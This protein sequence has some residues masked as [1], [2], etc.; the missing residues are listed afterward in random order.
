MNELLLSNIIPE[1][2]LRKV[3]TNVLENVSN[4]IMK[5]AGPYGS[6]TMIIRQKAFAT[7]SKDG[8]KVLDNIKYYGP[9][10][11][12]I[13]DEL[14]QMTSYVVKE[15]GDGT[16]SAIRMSYYIFKELLSKAG[17]SWSE[18]PTHSIIESFKKVTRKISDLIL[19]HGRELTLG[20]IYDICMVSTNGDK[21]ISNSIAMIYQKYGADVNIDIGTSNTA[22]HM[23]KEYDGLILEKGY[24]S[25][26]YINTK[27]GH[28]IINNANIYYFKDP[29]DTPEMVQ[30]FTAI[31]TN[32]IIVPI[33]ERRM[34]PIPTVIMCPHIS[35]DVEVYLDEI[36]T[37][38]Y[39]CKNENTKPPILII[40]GLNRY[41]E[42]LDDICRLCGAKPI[43][44]YIDPKIQEH[45][46]EAGKAPSCENIYQWCGKAKVVDADSTKTKFI[47]PDNMYTYNEDGSRTETEVYSGLVTFLQDQL[48]SAQEN[49]EDISVIRK[50]KKRLMA[51]SANMVQY[52]IGGI[53]T[54][55]VESAKDLTEDAVLNCRAACQNGIGF[56]AN[57]EGLIASY[58]LLN[59]PDDSFTDLD[60][61]MLEVIFSAY[62]EFSIELYA[63]AMKATEAEK[64]VKASIEMG[65]PMNLRTLKYD[66]KVLSSINTDAVIL[67][68][69]SRIII[70]MFTANQGLTGEP[71]EN[72]YAKLKDI[73][74]TDKN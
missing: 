3:Q 41:T 29:I 24:P 72:K 10:E 66:G 19:S 65:M 60:V 28:C 74:M 57:F 55:D 44:K 69:I 52:L 11:N 27:S 4:A 50:L 26:A 58:E 2:N 31:I 17:D 46:I 15:V 67:E 30:F 6:N 22:E 37:M 47:E 25:N 63:T 21:D 33:T 34:E 12:A 35:R 43:M 56:G 40:S 23:Y 9:L 1:E 16:T 14:S 64:E 38:L 53:S 18:Y 59:N 36:E 61:E 54:S 45:D 70:I 62:K 71:L 68:G 5:T 39:G 13:V 20:D 8:K 49:N 73:D 7:Y 51:L 42:E 32:N 48:K